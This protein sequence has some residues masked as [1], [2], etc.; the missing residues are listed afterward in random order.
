VKLF[1]LKDVDTKD[2]KL[3]E[4]KMSLEPDLFRDW[5]GS[6]RRA[7]VICKAHYPDMNLTEMIKGV[8]KGTKVSTT[9]KSVRGFDNWMSS[10]VSHESWYEKFHTP[11]DDAPLVYSHNFG[12]TSSGYGEGSSSDDAEDEKA[13][14]AAT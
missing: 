14:S 9:V 3:M 1:Y 4:F 11:T 13:E 5:Q 12:S 10:S 7:L 8:P 2:S 6:A